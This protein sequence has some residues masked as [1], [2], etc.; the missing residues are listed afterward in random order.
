MA[1]TLLNSTQCAA[2]FGVTEMS[3]FS[4]RGGTPTKAALPV[5]KGIPGN[6]KAVRFDADTMT[7][8]AKTHGL[9]F[10]LK[11]ATFNMQTAPAKSG[12]KAKVAEPV[13]AKK[14]VVAKKVAAK[15]KVKSTA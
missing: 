10:D 4:W 2:G 15:K 9:T 8:Y 14:V 7:K 1:K 12:P 6:P 11:A 3:I 5:V 13:A